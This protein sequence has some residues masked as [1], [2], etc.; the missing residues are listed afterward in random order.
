MSTVRITEPILVGDYLAGELV[1]PVKHEYVAGA[2]FAMVGAKNSHNRIAVN[3]LLALGTQLKGKP[4]QPCNSDT[5]IR[6]RTADHVRF[7]YPDVS[8]VCDANSLSDTFQ[9]RPVLIVEV[10]SEST[11]RLDDGEKRDAYFTIPTLNYY[12]LLEQDSAVAVLYERASERFERHE[13][14]NLND[15]IS[16]ASLQIKLPL[17]ELY[18]GVVK[19]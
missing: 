13:F 19:V 11:R 14:T 12:L 17:S 15:V 7:Y 18:L 4:C 9:D 1:S 16:L 5:K 2:V 10:L 6:V 8:V 3:A